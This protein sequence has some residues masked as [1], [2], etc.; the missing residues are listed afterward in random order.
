MNKF[1]SKLQFDQNVL[2]ELLRYGVVGVF[3]NAIGYSIYL[4]IT[5]IGVDP[6]LVLTLLYGLAAMVGFWGHRKVTFQHSG[7]VRGSG[8][9]YLIAHMCGYLL[10]LTLLY[11]LVDHFKYP[12]QWVQL[13]CIFVV[14]SY[15]FVVLRF[16]VFAK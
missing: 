7:S 4:L 8:L 3:N 16:F 5:W 12:H 6:K 14:A 10:N 13:I 1:G 15:L 11:V 2:N 9:R